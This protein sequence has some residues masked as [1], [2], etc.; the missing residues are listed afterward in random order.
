MFR[1]EHQRVVLEVYNSLSASLTISKNTTRRTCIN[2][3]LNGRTIFNEMRSCAI[4]ALRR[5]SRIFSA[6]LVVCAIYHLLINVHI[7][8]GN[9]RDRKSLSFSAR[10]V[11]RF[12]HGVN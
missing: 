8:K 9:V 10:P 5:E 6:V 4:K 12:Q 3:L 2:R 7:L 1:E 11:V